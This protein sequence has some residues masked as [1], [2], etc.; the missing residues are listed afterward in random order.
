MEKNERPLP[1]E[2]QVKL[3]LGDWERRITK[4]TP[5]ESDQEY[6]RIQETLR[7]IGLRIAQRFAAANQS[8]CGNCRKPISGR[9][10]VDTVPRPAPELPA[11]WINQFCC[12]VKCADELKAKAHERE[13]RRLAS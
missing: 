4:L 9:G 3:V 1:S 11:G 10:P 13:M 2:E 12:S 8:R 6:G 5:Q 7:L